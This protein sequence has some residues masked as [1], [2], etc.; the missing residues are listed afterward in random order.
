MLHVFLLAIREKNEQFINILGRNLFG[1]G[2]NIEEQAVL[3]EVVVLSEGSFVVRYA[4]CTEMRCVVPNHPLLYHL[5]LL[6]GRTRL[7]RE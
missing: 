6:C 5:W 3:A 4:S 7:N 2:N 1:G